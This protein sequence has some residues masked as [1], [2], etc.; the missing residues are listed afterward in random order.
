MIALIFALFSAMLGLGIVSPLLPVYARELGANAVVI[1]TMYSS[2]SIARTIFTPV[3]GLASDRVGRK[4]FIVFGLIAYSFVA[5]LYALSK[6]P[7]DLVIVRFFHGLCSAMVIPSAMAYVGQIAPEGRE[8]RVISSFN[9]ALLAGIGFG[10][11]MGGIISDLMGIRYAFFF[12]AILT[13]LAFFLS[14]RIPNV[15]DGKV[16]RR[17]SLGKDVVALT[18]FRFS[19]AIRM[20]MMLAFFPILFNMSKSEIGTV[21]SVMILSNALSQKVFAGFIDR[22]DKVKFATLSGLVATAFFLTIPFSNHY[23]I[24]PAVLM[25]TFNGMTS[26]SA[27]SIAVELGRIYGQGTVMG[28][29]N[30]GTSLAMMVIPVTAGFIADLTS[31]SFSFVVMGLLSGAFLLASSLTL[32][33]EV[34]VCGGEQEVR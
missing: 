13:A 29:Y 26:C 9:I 16:R 30:T 20:S 6:S 5:L 22:T 24:V 34:K 4:F 23:V 32:K 11:F 33:R 3:F 14:L 15:K 18:L 28:L 1:G 8:G 19:I 25:G 10:P 31:I 2:F 7:E 17:V 21:I 12:M 27:S